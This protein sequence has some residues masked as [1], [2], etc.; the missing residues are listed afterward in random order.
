MIKIAVDN[1][2]DSIVVTRADLHDFCTAG[3]YLA[4][5]TDALAGLGFMRDTVIKA[6]AA[7]VDEYEDYY[8]A[9]ILSDKG[10]QE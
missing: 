6:M 8:S 7:L 3:D 10:E 2:K 4:L 5:F 9:K 1:G